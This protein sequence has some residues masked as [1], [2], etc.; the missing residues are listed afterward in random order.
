MPTPQEALAIARQHQQAGNLQEAERL[1]GQILS[2][3]PNC[4]EAWHF[5]GGIIQQA[6]RFDLAA[7]YTQRA[8]E[9]MPHSAAVH[10]DFATALQL[11]GRFDEAV[12]ALRRAIELEPNAEA[13]HFNLGNALQAQGKQD[14]AI[15]VYRRAVELKPDF[16]PALCNLAACL[17]QQGKLQEALVACRAC[18]TADPNNAQCYTILGNVFK[19]L[20]MLKE[21][22]SAIQHALAIQPNLVQALASVGA[23]YV[24]Q[25]KLTEAIWCCNR[26]LELRPDYAIAHNNLGTALEY[27]GNLLDAAHC[28]SRALELDPAN[29]YVHVSQ[30][31]LLLLT[32]NFE[33]GWDEYEWRWKT[34][35]M[36]EREFP[37]PKWEGQPLAGRT[38]LLHAEQGLGDTLQFIRYAA[39]VKR[40]GAKVVVEC[41]ATLIPLLS[42]CP[43]IDQLIA[44]GENVPQTDFHLPLLSL[45]RV[46]KTSLQTIPAE[47]PYLFADA[48]LVEHWRAKLNRVRGF[49][50]GVN[51][52][53]RFGNGRRDIPLHLVAAMA[54]MPALSL[55]ILQKG[56]S[57]E[58]L[59][60][61]GSDSIVTNPGDD[62]DRQHGAFMD[63]AAIMM[64]LDLVITS[65]T[66]VAHLAGGL[67]VPVWVALPFIA[68]WRWLLDRM[69]SPW[70]PTMRLFRQKSLGDWVGAFAEI[71]R[72]L[73]NRAAAIH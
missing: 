41:P 16:A 48:A 58:E 20:N 59:A 23:V 17:H 30:S 69:D 10:S 43:G 73:Q 36:F 56:A 49:Q 65:D 34:N 61:L 40:L 64:N 11:L 33:R 18:L 37:V 63:T 50:V 45:P 24:E 55:V 35:L 13:L 72:E 57:A 60:A 32:G 2:V 38:I 71:Y 52:H 29:P 39:Q 28:F 62:L 51:W 19:S 15:A 4:G 14:N 6:G 31:G 42:R 66:S 22:A 21:A 3:D 27:T 44:H 25:D 68:E 8:A 54:R 7:Q 5:L 46:L 1:Y 12:A 53:G 26:A 70:Y 9:L 47:V 67:G